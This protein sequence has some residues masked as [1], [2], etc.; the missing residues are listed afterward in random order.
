[1][2]E[3]GSWGHSALQTPA[4]VCFKNCT[5]Y[6]RDVVVHRDIACGTLVRL[7]RPIISNLGM[8]PVFSIAPLLHAC[9]F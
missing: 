6:H 4:L 2:L 1:M 5:F 9:I 7:N 3:S 8:G